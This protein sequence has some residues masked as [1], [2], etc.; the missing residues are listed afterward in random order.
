MLSRNID[1]IGVGRCV[2]TRLLIEV[3]VQHVENLIFDL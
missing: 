2:W 1:K 3:F